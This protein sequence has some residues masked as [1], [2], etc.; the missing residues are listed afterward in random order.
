VIG[1]R[2]S[3]NILGELISCHFSHLL[4]LHSGLGSRFLVSCLACLFVLVVGSAW[5][6][7]IQSLHFH[8]IY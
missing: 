2:I 1:S 5:K 4:S 7:F 8:F 6:L 3:V